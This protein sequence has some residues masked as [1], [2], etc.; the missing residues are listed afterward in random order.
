MDK[1]SKYDRYLYSML[2]VAEHFF[3]SNKKIKKLREDLSESISQ[4]IPDELGGLGENGEKHIP[5]PPPALSGPWSS[6]AAG[7]LGAR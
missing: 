7:R 3:G 6:G 4:K 2:W 1:I 5:V